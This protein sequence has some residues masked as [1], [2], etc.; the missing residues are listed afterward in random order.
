MQSPVKY[1]CRGFIEGRKLEGKRKQ[2][3]KLG[4]PYPATCSRLEG[5]LYSGPVVGGQDT[6]WGQGLA[7]TQA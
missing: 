4:D 2:A 3:S 6:A 1:I 7:S 5:R